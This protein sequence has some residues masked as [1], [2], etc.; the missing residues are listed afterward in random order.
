MLTPNVWCRWNDDQQQDKT[1][2][3]ER[4]AADVHG[5]GSLSRRQSTKPI[6][7]AVSGGAYGGGMEI[8]L[9]CDI[10]VVAEGSK[11]ALPEIVPPAKVL[12]T[13]LAVAQ[14][15]VANSPDAVQA[16]KE[17]LLL[18]QQLNFHETLLAN[19]ASRASTR[20]YKGQNI[21]VGVRSMK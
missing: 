3:Q 1:D 19:I 12:P 2:E 13:A 6:I 18:S 5:F 16:T 8:L 9:N 17:G 20:V 10:V 21:K 15:I 11:F 7:A 4:I 14:E